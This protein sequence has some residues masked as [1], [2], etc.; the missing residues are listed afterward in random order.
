M[1]VYFGEEESPVS[2]KVKV[3]YPKF[4]A[5]LGNATATRSGHISVEADNIELTILAL[6][7]TKLL[8]I[9]DNSVVEIVKDSLSPCLKQ[10]EE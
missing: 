3:Q 6:G 9:A 7:G 10:V 4:L 1:G 2:G 5:D 8:G